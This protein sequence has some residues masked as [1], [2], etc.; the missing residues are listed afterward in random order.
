MSKKKWLTP[1]Q[2]SAQWLLTFLT[3]A[4]WASF[5]VLAYVGS[6]S[7]YTADDFCTAGKLNQLGFWPAQRFWYTQWSGRYAFTFIISLFEQAGDWFSAWS[8]L[9][10]ILLFLLSS[11]LFV[12]SLLNHLYFKSGHRYALFFASLLV[13]LTLFSTPDLAQSLLWMTGMV[14]Y[15]LPIV[16]GLGLFSLLI[17]LFFGYT[18]NYSLSKILQA[19]VI[20]L[21]AWFTSGFSEVATA[22]L[23]ILIALVLLFQRFFTDK[24]TWAPGW[25]AA[26]VG[27]LLGLTML[28]FAP[29][30]AVRQASGFTN[31]G[32]FSLIWITAKSSLTYLALWLMKNA[33]LIWAAGLISLL[34]GWRF[35]L[36][37]PTKKTDKAHNLH[38][39]LIFVL[40]VFVVSFLPT[41]WAL[42]NKPPDRALILP[43]LILCLSLLWVCFQGGISLAGRIK[44]P[45]D[46]TQPIFV[47]VCV[48]CAYFMLSA[49]AYQAYLLW[50][51]KSTHS[52]YAQAWDQRENEINQ[53]IKQGTQQLIVSPL[54]ENPYALEE[55]T[56]DAQHWLNVCQRDYYEVEQL[57]IP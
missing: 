52:D 29:G 44:L 6:F 21:L 41:S 39:L 19:V 46:L 7:R 22:M 24:K 28:Y 38:W 12:N 33:A 14:T 47:A 35:S 36:D 4:I 57:R 56:A 5:F 20:M 26:F 18:Q 55:L 50:D 13:F 8:P 31:T 30:N 10:G 49:P 53:Q 48:V 25:L 51:N 15:L 40:I 37:H 54:P 3:L 32:L 16:F 17:R 2:Q 23:T 27:T 43:T 11:Y 45:P 34:V 9:L 1:P 42:G